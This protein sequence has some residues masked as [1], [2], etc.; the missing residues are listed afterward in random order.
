MEFCGS[1]DLGCRSIKLVI[2]SQQT[3]PAF[4]HPSLKKGGEL[5]ELSSRGDEL[6]NCCNYP[7]LKG[8][9]PLRVLLLE[10]RRRVGSFLELYK[11]TKMH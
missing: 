8:P 11:I 9:P 7:L 1:L 10:K 5:L 3:T 2:Y 4:G 6:R